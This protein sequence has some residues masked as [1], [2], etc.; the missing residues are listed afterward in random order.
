MTY[1]KSIVFNITSAIILL[2][3]PFVALIRG[4]VFLHENYELFS[5]LSILGGVFLSAL[6]LFIY[7][8]FIQ[9]R[10]TG[11]VGGFQGIKRKY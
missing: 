3:L 9:G 4:A 5:W 8:V 7:F 10:L 1:L 6:V 2:V 11:K